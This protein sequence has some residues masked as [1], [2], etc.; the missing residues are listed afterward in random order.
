MSR[1]VNELTSHKLQVGAEDLGRVEYSPGIYF[2]LKRKKADFVV[3]MP[4]NYS[5]NRC[6]LF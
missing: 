6:L 5:Y 3:L 1:T 2:R 4:T